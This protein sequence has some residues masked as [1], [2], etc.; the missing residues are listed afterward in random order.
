MLPA[1]TPAQAP[2][3]AA[4]GCRQ[5]AGRT[6]GS[7]RRMASLRVAAAVPELNECLPARAEPPHRCRSE[8]HESACGSGR[9]LRRHTRALQRTCAT[10]GGRHRPRIARPLSA[11]MQI[12]G[13]VLP[14]SQHDA[15]ARVAAPVG[16]PSIHHGGTAIAPLVPR[17]AWAQ[18]AGVRDRAGACHATHNGELPW[19]SI[20]SHG[21]WA[22]QPAC[23]C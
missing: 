10:P 22:F 11:I 20:S 14:K 21:C 19:A 5:V 12:A 3:R 23:C 6:R 2:G 9:G 16:A 17:P 4:G 7:P 1:S 15:A 13:E 18:E 8:L